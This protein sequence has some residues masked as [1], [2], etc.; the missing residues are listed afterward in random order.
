MCSLQ[1][2][3]CN[4]SPRNLYNWVSILLLM[5]AQQ[6]FMNRRTLQPARILCVCVCVFNGVDTIDFQGASLVD[7]R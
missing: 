1:S 6:L 7:I 3:R 5:V 4:E 2:L